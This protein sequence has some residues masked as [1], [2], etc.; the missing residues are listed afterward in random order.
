MRGTDVDQGGLFSYVS[1]EQRIPPMRPLHR[2][3]ALLDEALEAMSR[4]FDRVYAEGG[5]RSVAPER[6]VWALVLP[7]LCSIRS[8]RLLGEQRD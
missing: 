4:D 1:M 5:R 7:V 3:R 6:L 2:I 8:E